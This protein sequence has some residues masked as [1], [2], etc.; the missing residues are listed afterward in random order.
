MKVLRGESLD[1]MLERNDSNCGFD[2]PFIDDI[3]LKKSLRL[4]SWPLIRISLII[5][6]AS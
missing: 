3:F 2:I 4:F 1:T 5:Y 6:M